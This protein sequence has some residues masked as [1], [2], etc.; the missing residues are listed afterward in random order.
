MRAR[1]LGRRGDLLRR[2][3]RLLGR[4]RDLL[5]RRRRLLGE[6]GDLVGRCDD[7]AR[8]GCGCPRRR[9]RSARTPPWRPPRSRTTRRSGVRRPRRP[10]PSAPSRPGSRRSAA[11]IDA[12]ACC[13]SSASLRTSSATT[14][15]PRPCSPA[16][17]ASMAAFSASRLVW[18]AMPVIVS[19]MPPICSDLPE[20]DWI[21]SVISPVDARSASI[22]LLACSAAATPS[23]ATTAA[24][25]GCG[26]RLLGRRCGP[27]RHGATCCSAPA[28]T[29]ATAF[30]ISPTARPASSEVVAICCDEAPST[31]AR[32]ETSPISF[33]ELVDR[34]VVGG[35]GADQALADAVD[36]LRDRPDLVATRALDLLGDRVD[37]DGEVAV[38]QLLEG[39][40]EGRG[41][42]LLEG[43]EPVEHR[44]DRAAD[45]AA[46]EKCDPKPEQRCEHETERRERRG[47]R[48]RVVRGRDGV[49]DAGVEMVCERREGGLL[50]LVEPVHDRVTGVVVVALRRVHGL[51]RRDVLGVVDGVAGIEVLHQL[52]GDGVVARGDR[53]LQGLLAR[54]DGGGSVL[55]VARVLRVLVGLGAAQE[56][57]L[58]LLVLDLEVR[59]QQR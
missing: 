36:S 16:R 24:C 25:A 37:G 26:T 29:S 2:R 27:R 13:D 52:R 4:G 30:A 21:A 34:A 45:A 31:V 23:P 51:Q 47:G 39:G 3:R 49:C 57:V 40:L 41:V 38:G 50:G 55:E 46:Q 10:R 44:G 56:D 48:L 53:G 15:K 58:Q 20:S 33:C 59:A 43:C 7:A 32:S 35:N 5:G 22:A 19:T 12:A 28:A 18:P 9:R 6:R 17:A 14:A 1:S 42:V 11:A 8:C 54:D